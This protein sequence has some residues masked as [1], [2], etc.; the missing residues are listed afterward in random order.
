MRIDARAQVA[1]GLIASRPGITSREI[2]ESLGWNPSVGFSA[3][4]R[5][6]ELGLA[7]HT[8]LGASRPAPRRLA[9]RRSG[10]N[11][12]GRPFQWWPSEVPSA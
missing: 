9:S 7:R 6:L 4:R 8:T 5:A 3:L 2:Y 1:A 11:P 10:S 12:T